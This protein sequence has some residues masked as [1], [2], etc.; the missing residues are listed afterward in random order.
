MALK[1]TPV[2]PF[3]PACSLFI[4]GLGR[5]MLRRSLAFRYGPIELI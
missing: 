3:D 4:I 2:W 1:L 5:M